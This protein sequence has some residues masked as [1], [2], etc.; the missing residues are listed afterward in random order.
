MI[1]LIKRFSGIDKNWVMEMSTVP[2]RECKNGNYNN[3][4]NIN[5][6]NFKKTETVGSFKCT[7]TEN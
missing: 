1:K 5:L 3:T 7:D 4:Q 6:M 2:L